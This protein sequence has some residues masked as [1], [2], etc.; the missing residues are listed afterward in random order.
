MLL[1]A[2]VKGKL[3]EALA[4]LLL[5]LKGCRIL[6]KNSRTAGIEADILALKGRT[7]L[8]VEVK[9]RQ[10]RDKAHQALHPKQRA[11]LQRQAHE[12]AHR[13]PQV[14]NVQLDVVLFFPHAPFVEYLKNPL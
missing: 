14:E 7:L 4:R 8:V 1:S 5:R 2:N 13:Y 11:R 10:T 6:A 12:L 3:F 9:Y